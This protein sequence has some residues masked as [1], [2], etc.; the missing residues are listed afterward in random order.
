M[1]GPLP[2]REEL[3]HLVDLAERGVLTPSEARLL[4]AGVRRL[5]DAV[6]APGGEQR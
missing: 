4:R 2:S 6:E 1:N 5:L 3:L